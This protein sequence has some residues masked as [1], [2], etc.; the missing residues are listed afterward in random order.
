MN[1]IIPEKLKAGDEIRIISPSRSMSI[2]SK[3]TIKVAKERLEELGLKVTFGKNVMET[4]PLYNCATVEQRMEDLHEAFQDKNVK[5]ILT[6]IGG[7]NCNQLLGDIDYELIRNNPKIFCGYSDITALANGIYAKTDMVTYSGVHFSSLGMKKGFEYSLD[8]FKKMFMQEEPF[9]IKDSNTW[10]DDP[11][12]L[13]QENREFINNEGMICIHE[14]EAEGKS[15]GGNLCTFNLLQGTPY[16]PSLDNGILFV[17]DDDLVGEEFFV[18]FDRDLQSI[19]HTGYSIKGVLI[20]RA[21][22]K[23][24]MTIQKWEMLINTK[25]ELDGVP[26]IANCNFGHTTPILTF[27]IGGYVKMKASKEGNKIEIAERRF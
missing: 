12:Y 5:G 8:Y 13:D 26:V 21:Q 11:W 7:Y 4:N 16:M 1:N 22:K 20:G 27:P 25:K 18:E 24:K 10:S 19:L 23:S 15:I 9:E 17:E 6:V 2:L 14:G 3:E